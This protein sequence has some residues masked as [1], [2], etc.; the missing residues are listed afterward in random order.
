MNYKE[1]M[2]VMTEVRGGFVGTDRVG[3]GMGPLEAFSGWQAK[4]H[5]LVCVVVTREFPLDASLS[6]TL[7]H[8][9][10]YFTLH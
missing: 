1:H 4:C 6:D 3:I 5:F 2:G 7:V 8:M 9:V 10:F